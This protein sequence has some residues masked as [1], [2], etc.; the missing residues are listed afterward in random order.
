MKEDSNIT[1]WGWNE[2]NKLGSLVRNYFVK[3]NGYIYMLENK[4]IHVLSINPI[5]KV[6]TTFWLWE[7]TKESFLV[8]GIRSIIL[9]Y[10]KGTKNSIIINYVETGFNVSKCEQCDKVILKLINWNVIRCGMNNHIKVVINTFV[11]WN[12]IPATATSSL[13]APRELPDS[14]T[15]ASRRC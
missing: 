12:F 14:I 7:W 5:V 13:R 11:V 10:K 8:V 4:K 2:Y 1:G 15:S 6:L 3:K 9:K